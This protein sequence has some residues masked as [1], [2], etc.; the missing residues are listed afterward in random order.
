M[1]L[2]C[3]FSI[4]TL[5]MGEREWVNIILRTPV[6]RLVPT[7]PVKIVWKYDPKSA[8]SAENDQETAWDPPWAMTGRDFRLR[9]SQDLFEGFKDLVNVKKPQQAKT[10]PWQ[11]KQRGQY[12]TGKEKH[13]Q[14][15]DFKT[16][17][18]SNQMVAW[19]HFKTVPLYIIYRHH[20][21]SATKRV[22]SVWCET[23][24]CFAWGD[25]V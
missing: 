18:Q 6:C 7:E 13:T 15:T 22:D 19:L 3:F 2:Y 14:E 1:V 8:F 24:V 20:I 17:H 23:K 4:V 9:D 5:H 12:R 25:T 11:I 16:K 10:K 21:V